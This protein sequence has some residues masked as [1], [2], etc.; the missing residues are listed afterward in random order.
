MLLRVQPRV[1]IVAGLAAQAFATTMMR[2]DND[3]LTGLGFGVGIALL[4]LGVHLLKK[5]R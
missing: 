3:F 4:G 2:L 5:T 1:L